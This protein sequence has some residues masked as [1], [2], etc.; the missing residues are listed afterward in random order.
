MKKI[1]FALVGIALALLISISIMGLANPELK[2]KTEISVNA[3]KA[4][5]FE[6]LTDTTFFKYWVTNFKSIEMIEG[7]KDSVG[8][9]YLL[10]VV[11]DGTEYDMYKTVTGFI[12]DDYYAYHLENDVMDSYVEINLKI[13]KNKTDIKVLNRVSGKNIFRRALFTFYLSY[14]KSKDQ[15]QYN[16]L[17]DFI[18]SQY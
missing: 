7:K 6:I 3:P 16:R 10:K 8:S 9:R 13:D 12:Q 2:F 11:D 14:F 18:E 4:W 1:L 17:R 5:S 15:E